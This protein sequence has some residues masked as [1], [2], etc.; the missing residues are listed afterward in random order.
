MPISERDWWKS[1]AAWM[2]DEHEFE[3]PRVARGA[4]RERPSIAWTVWQLLVL[5]ALGV[6]IVALLSTLFQA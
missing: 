2:Y 5:L 4:R 3:E 1:S 6:V